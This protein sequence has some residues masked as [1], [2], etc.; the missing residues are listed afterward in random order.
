MICSKHYLFMIMFIIFFQSARLRRPARWDEVFELT[1]KYPDGTYS[2][3]H[4]VDNLVSVVYSKN[5]L[6]DVLQ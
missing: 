6:Y 3:G 1:H 2:D 4:G 5:K